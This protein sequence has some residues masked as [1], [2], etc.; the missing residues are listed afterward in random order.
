MNIASLSLLSLVL[1]LSSSSLLSSSLLI[2]LLLSFPE[3]LNI[4]L[5]SDFSLSFKSLHCSGVKA[6]A[7]LCSLF[8]SF[9]T[10]SLD[11]SS[12][13]QVFPFGKNRAQPSLGCQLFWPHASPFSSPHSFGY[14]AS[15][16]LVFFSLQKRNA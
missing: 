14:F 8:P 6:T 7:H 16:F 11:K 10:M 2:S 4:V 12:L 1:L 3:K 15:F 13:S 9:L 5:I